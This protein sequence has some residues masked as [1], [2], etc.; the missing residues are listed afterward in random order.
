VMLVALFTQ[1]NICT[2]RSH[3]FVAGWLK[4]GTGTGGLRDVEVIADAVKAREVGGIPVEEFII[5]IKPSSLRYSLHS[6]FRTCSCIQHTAD[7]H[8]PHFPLVWV[9]L[10]ACAECDWWLQF[11]A[12]CCIVKKGS[13]QSSEFRVASILRAW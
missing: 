9:G 1:V 3:S 12:S 8:L 7:K 6:L 4:K 5:I 10:H 2:A 11:S 13:R